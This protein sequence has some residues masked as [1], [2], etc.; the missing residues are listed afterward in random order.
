M[1]ALSL[2]KEAFK[3][4]L[5]SCLIRILLMIVFIPYINVLGIEISMIIS[6]LNI[7]LRNMKHIN[8]NLFK[9]I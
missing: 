8:N 6:I 3:T 7:I 9:R 5:Y 2:D 4:T 1:H